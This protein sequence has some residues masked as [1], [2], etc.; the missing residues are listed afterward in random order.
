[1]RLYLQGFTG[2]SHEAKIITTLGFLTKGD[3]TMWA[4]IKKEEAIAK[5][6]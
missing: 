6:L 5:K 2:L 1:M 4:H 3:A